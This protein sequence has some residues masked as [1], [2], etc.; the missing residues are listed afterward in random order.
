MTPDQLTGVVTSHLKTLCLGE[1]QL[2]AHPQVHFALT[3]LHQ[4]AQSAGF[5]LAI[6]SG[7]RDFFRQKLIWDNK[8]SGK[9]PLLDSQSRPVD[10]NTLSAQE[11]VTTIMRW[12]AL[13]GA[14]RHHWGTD[15]DIYAKN[16]L[17]EGQNLVLEP[18]EYLDGHQH[19]FY[20]WLKEA[21]RPLGFFFPYDQDRGG[22][23]AEPWHISYAPVAQIAMKQLTPEQ[24]T[25]VWAQNPI[26]GIDTVQEILPN[27]Y[28]RYI[29][30]I[31]SLS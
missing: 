21:I 8:F 1:Q 25:Q 26:E 19:S 23:A 16:C 22:V 24:L 7:F 6:A 10:A 28:T 9:R 27:I 18:W 5:E 31:G 14:S 29:T 30:N 12:S 17:P 2:L 4:Q 11:K 3:Q 20:Q 15:F 13:P